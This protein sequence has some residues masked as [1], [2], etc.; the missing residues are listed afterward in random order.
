M[1]HCS[2]LATTEVDWG[3][4][5]VPI[6]HKVAVLRPVQLCSSW[7]DLIWLKALCGPS[8]IAELLVN[9]LATDQFCDVWSVVRTFIFATSRDPVSKWRHSSPSQLMGGSWPDLT[10]S[11]ITKYTLFVVVHYCSRWFFHVLWDSREARFCYL[12]TDLFNR[13]AV[14]D[15][16]FR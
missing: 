9:I 4:G 10:R 3:G 14:T 6:Q 5:W 15:V 16:I 13:D 2:C 1:Q 8:A 7:Q 11:V 12:L